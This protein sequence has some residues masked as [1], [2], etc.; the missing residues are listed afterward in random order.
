MSP[1]NECVYPF[2]HSYTWHVY[3]YSC[4]R[5]TWNAQRHTS[6]KYTHPEHID[7][8]KSP[9]GGFSYFLCSLIK[10]RVQEDPPR[11]TWYKSLEGGPLTHSS[12]WGNIV[13][14][15]PPRGRGVL[16]INISPENECVYPFT[17]SYKNMYIRTHALETHAVLSRHT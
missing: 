7:R 17:H 16:S 14:R 15:K 13:N 9:P 6:W 8:K 12:W 3:T 5:D 1:A 4:S 10:N 11:R 2:T